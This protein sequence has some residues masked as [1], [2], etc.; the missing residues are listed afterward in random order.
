MGTGEDRFDAFAAE[1]GMDPA[2]AAD[3]KKKFAGG[4]IGRGQELA[5]KAYDPI[6]QKAQQAAEFARSPVGQAALAPLGPA[7]PLVQGLGATMPRIADAIRPPPK[8]VAQ[9]PAFSRPPEMGTPAQ[10]PPPASPM[11]MNPSAVTGAGGPGGYS[12]KES[13]LTTTHRGHPVSNEVRSAYD[14]AHV[15][16]RLANQTHLEAAQ[17]K[18]DLEGAYYAA[19]AQA[20]KTYAALEDNA[21]KRQADLLAR[22]KTKLQS[23][24]DA[25][26]SGEIDPKKHWD[27]MGIGSQILATIGMAMGAGVAVRTGSRNFAA[28]KINGEIEQSIRAQEANMNNKKA[29]VGAQQS[30]M[31][32]NARQFESETK[33]RLATH[34]MMLEGARSEL[35][36]AMS[37]VTN[38]EAIANAQATDAAL[39]QKQA[40]IG[41]QFDKQSQDDV[42][43]QTQDAYMQR[44]G[45]AGKGA[46]GGAGGL[47]KH[48]DAMSADLAK[49]LVRSG[50]PQ[51]HSSLDQ[52]DRA[53]SGVKGNDIPG[54]GAIHQAASLLGGSAEKLEGLG[55]SVLGSKKGQEIRQAVAHLSNG[56]L[57]DASGAAVSDQELMRFKQ[58]MEGARDAEGFRRGL[59]GYRDR[60]RQLEG[61]IRSGFAPEINQVQAE[62]N[63][64]YGGGTRAPATKVNPIQ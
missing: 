60:V 15:D 64:A 59:E 45:G 41:Q 57:K 51:A 13:E 55:Y 18:G 40:E 62:R 24:V 19:Q 35:Q 28:D 32:Q 49:E 9:V 17:Q 1:N 53:L 27:E 10:P 58:E 4:I 29:A 34:M 7:G 37:K 46:G 23:L 33:G 52:I 11:G 44:S 31:D 48:G 2:L 6:A 16:A 43:V 54:F 3:W 50:I 14:D 21:A 12:T 5:S 61:V 63:A 39:A 38:K 20:Q 8:D 47:G 56:M 30:L 42:T 26:G 22:D 36:S 25:V